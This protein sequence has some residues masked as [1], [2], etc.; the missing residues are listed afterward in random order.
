MGSGLGDWHGP[1]RRVA[2]PGDGEPSWG[3]AVPGRDW[4]IASGRLAV[5]GPRTDGRAG[6]SNDILLFGWRLDAL[7]AHRLGFEGAHEYRPR[8][9]LPGGKSA[10]VCRVFEQ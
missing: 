10:F 8:V 2:A 3:S 6:G 4:E 1:L 7:R 9:F 5:G